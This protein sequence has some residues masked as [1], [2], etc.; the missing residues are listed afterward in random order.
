MADTQQPQVS[1]VIPL[2]RE[3]AI[4][5]PPLRR[6][7]EDGLKPVSSD[8]AAAVQTFEQVLSLYIVANVKKVVMRYATAAG[9]ALAKKVVGA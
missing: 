8:P 5:S 3:Y 4:F 6:T 9:A 1:N 2:K 7:L